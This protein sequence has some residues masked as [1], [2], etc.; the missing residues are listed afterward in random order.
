MFLWS[1]CNVV[2]NTFMYGISF[3]RVRRVVMISCRAYSLIEIDARLAN[4]N[5]YS[6]I[7]FI[8]YSD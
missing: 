5:R 7:V 4:I 8:S 2:A 6:F 1:V 3:I